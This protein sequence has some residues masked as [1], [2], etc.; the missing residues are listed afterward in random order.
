MAKLVTI[1][2][3]QIDHEETGKRAR[4]E[5]EKVGKTLKNIGDLMVLS[6]SY[7]SDLERGRRNWSPT[8][9]EQF[10]NALNGVKT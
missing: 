3:A 6:E 5:R 10:N 1:N 8:L 7:L 9:I 2:V 4:V